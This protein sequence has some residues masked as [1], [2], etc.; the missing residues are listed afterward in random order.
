MPQPNQIALELSETE[1]GAVKQAIATLKSTLLPRLQTLSA[2]ERLELP[3]M[4]DKTVAFVQ[5][6]HEYCQIHA[7]LV[8]GF[9]DT[10]AFRVDLQAVETLKKLERELLPLMDAITD[11]L[12]LSGSEAYQAALIFYGN[13]RQAAKLKVGASAS[14][15]ADLADRFPGQGGGRKTVH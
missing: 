13:A 9:L 6:C 2:Q 11:S 14:V 4:G 1:L 5:K 3:K 7:D 12:L 8:P 15:Y 10:Q